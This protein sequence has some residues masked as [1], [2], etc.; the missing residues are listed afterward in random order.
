MAKK[1]K[2]NIK[3]GNS[4]LSDDLLDLRGSCDGTEY[5][6]MYIIVPK[7]D[8]LKSDAQENILY[9]VQ[10][11]TV[12]SP[13]SVNTKEQIDEILADCLH[14][15][16]FM[17]KMERGSNHPLWKKLIKNHDKKVYYRFLMRPEKDG[18]CVEMTSVRLDEIVPREEVE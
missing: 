17:G 4:T 12:M 10:S 14:S 8:I 18:D 11:I 13:E 5:T 15:W 9:A 3:W 1:R 6:L 2:K 16:K 7:S